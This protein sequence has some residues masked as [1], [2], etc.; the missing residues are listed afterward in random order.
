MTTFKTENTDSKQ[1]RMTCKFYRY[2]KLPVIWYPSI[3][4][5]HPTS[6]NYKKIYCFHKDIKNKT[7]MHICSPTMWQLHQQRLTEFIPL[8]YLYPK[9]F[10]HHSTLLPRK[11]SPMQELKWKHVINLIGC[12]LLCVKICIL[13]ITP[14]D[15]LNK[16]A[17]TCSVCILVSKTCIF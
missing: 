14:G 13:Y 7:V 9:P 12:I 8:Q 5:S 1:N 10:T 3:Q 17:E 11:T 16:K 4:T 15:G 2:S 6:K